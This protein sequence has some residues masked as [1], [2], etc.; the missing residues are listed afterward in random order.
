MGPTWAAIATRGGV[1]ERTVRKVDGRADGEHEYLQMRRTGRRQKKMGRQA[2]G[3]GDFK[4][5]LGVL[6]RKHPRIDL[7]SCQRHRND[8]FVYRSALV[9]PSKTIEG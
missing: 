1:G 9:C 7:K 2:D 4:V 3:S 6:A 8:L 5:V